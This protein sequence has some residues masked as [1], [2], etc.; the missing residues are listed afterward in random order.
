MVKSR[1]VKHMS[2]QIFFIINLLF[3]HTYEHRGTFKFYLAKFF[4]INYYF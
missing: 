3:L 1:G 4:I 2:C